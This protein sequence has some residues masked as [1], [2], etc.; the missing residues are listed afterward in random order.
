MAPEAVPP[1]FRDVRYQ[2]QFVLQQSGAVAVSEEE[3]EDWEP[4][5]GPSV[6]LS[7]LPAPPNET[8]TPSPTE[9]PLT[10][11]H[12]VDHLSSLEG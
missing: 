10:S 3:F 1:P 9:A 6:L 8:T 12:P 11:C 5:V 2:S 4:Q 7:S